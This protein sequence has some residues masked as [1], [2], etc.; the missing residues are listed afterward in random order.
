ME[1]KLTKNQFIEA[2]KKDNHVFFGCLRRE[3]TTDELQLAID[4]F[5]KH[6]GIVEERTVKEVHATYLLFTDGNRLMLD[7]KG[8]KSYSLLEYAG[9]NLLSMVRE[10]VDCFGE[11]DVHAMYYLLKA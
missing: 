4:N 7:Q 5:I 8:N 10:S 1:K 6:D 9:Y 3:A 11:K 2:I